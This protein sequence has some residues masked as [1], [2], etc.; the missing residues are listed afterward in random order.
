[1]CVTGRLICCTWLALILYSMK[2]NL[3]NNKS[4]EIEQII[5]ILKFLEIW[6]L[7]QKMQSTLKI[8]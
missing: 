2:I 5:L 6:Y 3:F 7:S 4:V 1:M 8:N